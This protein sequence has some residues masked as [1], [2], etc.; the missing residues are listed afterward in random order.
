MQYDYTQFL[1]PGTI[2]IVGLILLG[3]I[4]LIAQK[5][6]SKSDIETLVTISNMAAEAA[7]QLVKSGRLTPDQRYKTTFDLITKEM[8][9]RG[10]H[11]T[12]DLIRVAIESAV[13]QVN[14]SKPI[15]FESV[16]I[17]GETH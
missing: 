2:T 11:I 13:L 4:R 1:T 12:L 10:I 9:D 6:L 15:E 5:F 16:E 3:I 8:S 17:E 14:N 7:E